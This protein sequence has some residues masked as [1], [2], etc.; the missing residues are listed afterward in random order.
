MDRAE[1][2]GRRALYLERFSPNQPSSLS[3]FAANLTTASGEELQS[4]SE[5]SQQ[6]AVK[7]LDP[8]T[9]IAYAIPIPTPMV[10]IEVEVYNGTRL[11]QTYKWIRTKI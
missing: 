2:C 1:A 7:A 8:V 10:R 5:W 3:Y 6:V 9:Y 4:F 11:I